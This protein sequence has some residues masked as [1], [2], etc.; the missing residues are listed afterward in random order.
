[1][2][3]NQWND[4]KYFR[5]DQPLLRQLNVYIE[6]EDPLLNYRNSID[7]FLS[8]RSQLYVRLRTKYFLWKYRVTDEGAEPAGEYTDKISDNALKQY[9]LDIAMF[10][11]LARNIGAVPILM[12]EPRLVRSDN[13]KEQKSRIKYHS[14]KLTHE[15]LLAAFEKTDEIIKDIAAKKQ[16]VLIDANKLLGAK[17]EL[18]KDQVHTTEKGSEEVAKIVASS[19]VELLEK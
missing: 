17:D 12:T 4:I 14:V 8:E 1:V 15:A 7:R 2:L 5:S 6:K 19:L 9:R 3:S 10:V 16:I 18:F 13:T 11:D